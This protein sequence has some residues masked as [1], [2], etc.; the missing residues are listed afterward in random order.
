M[1]A[2]IEPVTAVTGEVVRPVLNAQDETEEQ[3]TDKHKL[4][5]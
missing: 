4:L 3:R 5:E 1:F 2:G